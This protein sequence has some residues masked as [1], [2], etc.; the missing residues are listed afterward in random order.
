M[1][2]GKMEITTGYGRFWIALMIPACLVLV[3]GVLG[4]LYPDLYLG[5][6]L[7]QS[8]HTTREA[9]AAAQP[10]LYLLLDVLFRANGLG[11]TMSGILGVCIIG[12]AFRKG[13][14]W[15]LPALAVVGGIGLIGEIL[16]EI[17]ILR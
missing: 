5:F 14:R 11:M 1:K 17:M 12:F 9:V 13:K 8:T 7:S 10:E 6:Y 15:S 4:L 2:N 16:L 3:F